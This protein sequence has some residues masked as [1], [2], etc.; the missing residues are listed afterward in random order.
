VQILMHIKRMDRL[1]NYLQVGQVL[2][3]LDKIKGRAHVAYIADS[4][5]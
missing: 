3:V 5:V 4:P 1:I 2:Q